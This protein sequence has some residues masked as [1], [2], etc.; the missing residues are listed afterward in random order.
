MG[1]WNRDIP[2]LLFPFWAQH[3]VQND[4]NGYKIAGESSFENAQTHAII[5][6]DILVFVIASDIWGFCG[7]AV[8]CLMKVVGTSFIRQNV[9]NGYITISKIFFIVLNYLCLVNFWKIGCRKWFLF[10]R[11]DQKIRYLENNVGKVAETFG[12]IQNVQNCYVNTRLMKQ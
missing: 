6:R 3:G 2:K 1:I 10:R 4:R 12:W 7:N 5:Y 11:I 8:S 9:Y